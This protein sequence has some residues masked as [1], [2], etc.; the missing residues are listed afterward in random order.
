VHRLPCSRLDEG[1]EGQAG[2]YRCGPK[3]FVAKDRHLVA[4]A[5]EGAADAQ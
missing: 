1:L 4:P 3:L 2:R 5:S